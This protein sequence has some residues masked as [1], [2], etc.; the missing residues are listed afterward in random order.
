MS[1]SQYKKWEE[2]AKKIGVELHRE[3]VLEVVFSLSQDREMPAHSKFD[4]RRLAPGPH[5]RHNLM[6]TV[7]HHIET[8]TSINAHETNLSDRDINGMIDFTFIPRR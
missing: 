4:A 6:Q 8:I 5:A 2:T 3:I 1:S 7:R